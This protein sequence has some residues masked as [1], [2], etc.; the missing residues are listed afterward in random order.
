MVNPFEGLA[1][2]MRG[3]WMAALGLRLGRCGTATTADSEGGSRKVKM[4][5]GPLTTPVTRAG[6]AGNRNKGGR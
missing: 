1:R 6:N 4:P 5:R 2:R 3:V